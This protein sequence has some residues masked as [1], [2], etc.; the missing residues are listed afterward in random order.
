MFKVILI[1]FSA[2]VLA[3]CL[4]H[5]FNLDSKLEWWWR[6]KRAKFINK[7]EDYD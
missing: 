3:I 4:V 5:L 7:A 2:T 6:Y 1:S